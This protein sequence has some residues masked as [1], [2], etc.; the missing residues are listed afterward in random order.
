METEHICPVWVAYT[1]LL[2]VR[3]LR[4]NPQKILGPYIKEGMTAMDYGCAMGY[5][6]IPL[7]RM[8][9]PKGIV[10]CVDIQEKML[11]NLQKRAVRH[12][13]S[14]II[15]PLEV[16]K[17]YNPDELTGKLDFVLLFFVVHEVPDKKQLFSDLHKMLKPGGKILFAEP[18]GHV[19][20]EDFEK[21]L[22]LAKE[23]GLKV[24]NDKPG[25][26]GLCAFLLKE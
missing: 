7:A 12:N 23:A 2:P 10:Y 16:G 6:S 24:S 14:G 25:C 9:G 15:K 22:Q 5:F 11:A 18:K 8:T 4:H 19:N 3:K 1:F 26:R 17:N 21:S 20:P 13:V